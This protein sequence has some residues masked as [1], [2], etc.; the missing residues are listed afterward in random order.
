MNTQSPKTSGQSLKN[1]S[2][3]RLLTAL[4]ASRLPHAILLHG[5]NLKALEAFAHD[6][7]SQ[8]LNGNPL[9]HPD[10]FTLR[11]SNKMRQIATEDTRELISNL[12]KTPVLAN[13]KVAIIHEVDRMHL[14][15]A[16]AFLKTLEEPPSFTYILLLTTY[17]YRLPATIRSRCMFLSIFHEPTLIDHPLWENWSHSYKDWITL[18]ATPKSSPLLLILNLYNLVATFEVLIKTLSEDTWESTQTG[19]AD[20]LTEEE[21]ATLKTATQ[22]SIRNQVFSHMV[23]LTRN[24]VYNTTSLFP[25]LILIIEKLEQ[26][27]PL[28][29]VNLNESA[30]LEIFLLYSLRI[31]NS[32]TNGS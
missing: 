14:S 19:L 27:I 18:A 30:L 9:T 6:L 26:L 29:D 10:C 31:W 3:N 23:H 11:P 13:C 24:H 28:L 12:H 7:T 15:A 8:L 4:H 21:L 2:S 22:K 25:K 5:P 1:D 20:T 16:N 32:T 17:P